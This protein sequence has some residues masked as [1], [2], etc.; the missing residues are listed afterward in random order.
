LHNALFLGDEMKKVRCPDCN[1][2]FEIGLEEL[3][4]GDLLNCPECNLELVIEVKEG[5]PKLRVSKEK[6]LDET[7]FDEFYE[8]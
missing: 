5:K 2:S 3:D 1:E 7:D 8:E 6:E 4:E